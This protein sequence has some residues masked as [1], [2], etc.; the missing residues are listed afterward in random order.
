MAIVRMQKLSICATKSHR[1]EILEALQSLGAVQII[2]DQLDDPELERMDTQQ[3]RSQFEKSADS[4]DRVL[5]LLKTFAPE[6]RKGIDALLGPEAVGRNEADRVTAH[7]TEYLNDAAK[8]LKDD[9]EITECKAQI[10]KNTNLAEQLVPWKALGVPME[11]TGTKSAAVLIGTLPDPVT[12]EALQAQAAKDL[13]EPAAVSAEVLSSSSEQTCVTV[14]CLKRDAEKVENSLRSIGFARPAQPVKGVPAQVMEDLAADSEKQRARIVALQQDIRSYES[15][16]QAFR[17][18]ADYYRTRAEK[19]RILGMIPQS[20]NV[21]FIEG[22]V[23]RSQAERIAH[24]LEER[25]G[26]FVETE[27]MT[28]ED[29]EEEPTLLENNRF[30]RNA[31]GVL[32]SYGLPQH[33]HVDPTFI[34]SIFYVIF[35]GMMLSDAGYGI[36]MAVGTAV[37]LKKYPKMAEGTAK[38]LRL[39]FWCGLSTTFWGL[40]Y[41]GFFGNAVDTIAQNFFGYTG[42]PI[43]KP[44]WFEPLKDPM[45]LLVYCMLF[46]LIHLFAGLGIKG[47]ENLKNHDVTGFVSDVLAWYLFILGLVLMLIPSDIFASISG[48]KTVFPHPVNVLARVMAL[49]GAAL[50]LMMGGRDHKNWGIRIALGAYDLY[51]VSGWLSDVLSY[52]RLLAL[53]LATGVICNVINMMAVMGGR[54]VV[55]WIVFVIVFLLGHTMNLAINALGAYVHT[56]R[57][58]FVEFFGKFYDAG[59]KPFRPF[60]TVNQ[61]IEIKEEKTL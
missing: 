36:V 1:K 10:L 5:A 26:A 16:R 31:E 29:R 38:M 37:L 12:P 21:F 11:M 52:S 33:G 18:A 14:V 44:L 32:E 54:G 30:S 57:L 25:Y 46:G 4:F 58:Q 8:I 24:L 13:E 41:G 27:T 3:A 61:Y 28:G 49:A 43:V 19:Y 45:R 51:G 59:G 15:K 34:M 47:Y 56:N 23:A 55:G 35:F 53:G 7:R 60:K 39:F 42:D 17:I 2:T 22:W 6:N 50:I 48:A 40:M 9:R 20:K